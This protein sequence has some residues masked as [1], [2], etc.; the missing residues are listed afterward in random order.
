[1]QPMPTTVYDQPEIEYLDGRA[2]PKVS[3]KS[4][5]SIVQLALGGLI[6]ARAVGHGSTGT[7]WRFRPGVIDGSV[8][9]LV[10]DIAFVAKDRLKALVGRDL[11]EPPFSPDVAVEIRSPGDNVGYLRDKI[12]RYLAT[13]STLVLDVDTRTRR[14]RA[15]NV[16]GVREYDSSSTFQHASMPW[17]RFEVR[18]VFAGLDTLGV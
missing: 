2:H 14:I 1:M 12:R 13:G 4:P 15:Y 6:S 9:E 18:D 5:H 10:P 16:D 8:T 7:E 17:L 11:Q 3:P